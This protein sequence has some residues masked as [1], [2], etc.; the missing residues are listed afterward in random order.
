M[1]TNDTTISLEEIKAKAK[2]NLVEIPDWE[3][4]KMIKVR[5]RMIDVTPL[6]MNSGAIP[7]ELSVEVATMFEEGKIDRLSKDTKVKTSQF[8]DTLDAIAKEALVE[9]S[10]EA[11]NEIYPLTMQQKLAIFKYVTGGIELMKPFRKERK[12]NA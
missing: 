7:D 2:G 10:Y 5:L 12:G 3:P 6:I 4:T 9:P 11:I 8:A 1:S